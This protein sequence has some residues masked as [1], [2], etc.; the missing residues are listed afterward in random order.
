MKA[1]NIERLR[2][3]VRIVNKVLLEEMV[4]YLSQLPEGGGR[5]I[6]AKEKAEVF[7]CASVVGYLSSVTEGN[8]GNLKEFIAVNPASKLG[9]EGSPVSNDR[10]EDE[11]A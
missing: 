2:G 11:D 10:K 4:D 1:H 6:E 3:V 5:A 8:L 7:V 9:G